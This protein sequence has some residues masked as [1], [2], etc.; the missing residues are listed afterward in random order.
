MSTHNLTPFDFLISSIQSGQDETFLKVFNSSFSNKYVTTF[1]K[2]KK[3]TLL[4]YAADKGRTN[5]VDFLINKGSEISQVC[6]GETPLTCAIKAQQTDAAMA[7]IK[8]GA[9]VNFC[10]YSY[11]DIRLKTDLQL[12]LMRVGKPIENMGEEQSASMIDVAQEMINRGAQV[13]A[14]TEDTVHS[15]IISAILYENW[16]ALEMIL[17]APQFDI[18]AYV[19]GKKT[20]ALTVLGMKGHMKQFKMFIEHGAN[21]YIRDYNR[22]T[23]IDRLRT[24]HG[25]DN[26]YE[27]FINA[28]KE[29]QELQSEI[30]TPVDKTKETNKI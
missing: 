8:A 10:A 30:L 13:N 27:L 1:C 22:E 12:A 24:M 7:L 18:N 16:T 15:P 23:T 25:P 20:V 11:P 5:I 6:M 26:E 4:H 17:K 29:S 28:W 9:D 14:T 21:P 19:D 2:Q 3:W